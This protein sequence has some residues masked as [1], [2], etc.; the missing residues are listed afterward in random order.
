MLSIIVSSY[1]P[2]YFNQFSS[3]V[4]D[5]IG[6]D[7]LYEIIQIWNP[8]LMGICEAYNKGAEQSIHDNLLFIH[9]DVEFKTFEWG[10][11]LLNYLNNLEIGV[12]GLAGSDYVP[13]CPST[14]HI[15]K[16]FMHNNILQFDKE[17]NL[18]VE[19]TSENKEVYSLDGVF[20]GVKKNIY[21]QFKF[22][23]KL[24]DF[25]GYDIDFTIRV[26]STFK[27]LVISDIKLLHFSKGSFSKDLVEARILARS[28]YKIPLGQ[29]INQAVEKKALLMFIIDLRRI[30]FTKSKIIEEV[31]PYL[32]VKHLGVK[33][34]IK[35]LINIFLG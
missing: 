33:S 34:S 3:N 30:N 2:E 28:S 23:S 4:K 14:W 18:I 7:F 20:L 1:Q 9:E 21:N 24:K 35:F 11:K 19:N 15:D 13:N 16:K 31:L 25:H 12:V 8:G 27:N 5:T 26:S 29:K 17:N 22:N 6:E 10:E 32:S